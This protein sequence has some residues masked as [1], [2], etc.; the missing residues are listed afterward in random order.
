MIYPNYLDYGY[1]YYG[2]DVPDL[3]CPEHLHVMGLENNARG[4]AFDKLDQEE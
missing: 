4:K 2:D 3:P 1:D